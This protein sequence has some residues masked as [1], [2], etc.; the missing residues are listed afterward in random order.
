MFPKLIDIPLGFTT[1]PLN[2]FGLMVLSG[3]LAGLWVAGRRARA[4]GLSPELI[5]DLSVWLLLGGLLGARLVYVVFY[6]RY[7]PVLMR[8]EFDYD[9]FDLTDGG[10]HPLGGLAGFLLVLGWTWMHRRAAAAPAPS[11]EGKP[12]DAPPAASPEPK[13][14]G[15]LGPALL[16][17]LGGLA[18]AR[19][20]HVALDPSRYSL[21][22]FA[23]WEG[24]IVFYGGFIGAVA[25]GI[26]YLWRRRAPVLAVADIMAPSLALGM[27][28]GRMGCFLKGCC[29]GAVTGLPWGVRFPRIVESVL[30]DGRLCTEITGSPAFLQHRHEFPAQVGPEATH[31]LPV[32]PTQVYESLAMLALFALLSWYWARRPRP[33]RV[34]AGLGIGYGAWRFLVEFLRGDPHP[35]A[36][37]LNFSQVVS[38]GVVAAAVLLGLLLPRGAA[39][40]AAATAPENKTPTRP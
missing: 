2:T 40:P 33:G 12:E 4:R 18:G 37:H 39:S 21:K 20:L 29:Y 6:N 14:R 31:S 8:W 23:I 24:G 30:R 25:A 13:P 3:F 26:P 11:N 22:I 17:L 28:L 5:T 15:W 9:L 7:D 16:A 27:V 19:A 36:I 34:L 35:Q 1:I 32:H 10:L 38:L